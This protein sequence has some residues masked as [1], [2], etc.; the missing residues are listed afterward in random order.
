MAPSA[1]PVAHPP[2]A[3][4]RTTVEATPDMPSVA[5]G[6]RL[7]TPAMAPPLWPATRSPAAG[8]VVSMATVRPGPWADPPV[9]SVATIEKQYA[10]S[11]IE[12]TVA[13]SA[14]LEK[15][16][17]GCAPEMGAV[18]VPGARMTVCEL[19]RTSGAGVQRKLTGDANGALV[20]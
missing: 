19:L 16:P 4:T 9:T 14:E 20:S 7:T 12:P 15:T 1:V 8:L 18:H 6:V 13:L 11:G 17:I 10:P 3:P 2:V 5:A